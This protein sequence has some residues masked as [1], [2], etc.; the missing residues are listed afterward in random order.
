MPC[1]GCYQLWCYGE[2]VE[3]WEFEELTLKISIFEFLSVMVSIVRCPASREEK[4]SLP[5]WTVFFI[6]MFGSLSYIDLSDNFI[7]PQ[8]NKC[9]VLEEIL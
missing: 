5:M 6:K 1:V 8:M 3:G 4:Q 2:E 7:C 9:Q